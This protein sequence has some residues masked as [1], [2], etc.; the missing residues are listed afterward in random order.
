M[1]LKL[2]NVKMFYQVFMEESF[3]KPNSNA[4]WLRHFNGLEEKEIWKNMRG[5]VISTDLECLDYFIR[6]N[7]IFTEMRLCIMKKEQ[8]ALCKVCKNQDEGLLHLFLF[9]EKLRSFFKILKEMVNELRG[10]TEEGD[11]QRIIML[12]MEE[13][14]KNKGIINLLLVIAR[15]AIWKRRNIVKIRDAWI[16]VWILFKNIAK[17]YMLTLYN[18]WRLEGKEGVFFQ[19]YTSEV[20]N[21]LKKYKVEKVA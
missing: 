20:E 8:N 4:M 1:E 7:V 16:D 14:C 11:W 3:K 17:D 21:I 6:H 12:G 19:M 18:Y 5:P 13:K 10:K 2:G 9:C 15:K